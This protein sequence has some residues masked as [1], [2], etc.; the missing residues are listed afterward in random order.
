ML[1]QEPEETQSCHDD[2]IIIALFVVV[3]RQQEFR[4][5]LINRDLKRSKKEKQL[6][7]NKYTEETLFFTAKREAQRSELLKSHLSCIKFEKGEIGMAGDTVQA[8][9]PIHH[10]SPNPD[11]SICDVLAHLPEPGTRAR[12]LPPNHIHHV[13]FIIILL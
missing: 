12:E 9:D 5:I 3:T 4:V 7:I 10:S 1:H 2:H 13:V 6:K 8:K 11:Q